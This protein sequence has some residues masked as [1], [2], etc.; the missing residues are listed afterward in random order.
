MKTITTI[1][2]LGLKDGTPI[3]KGSSL[4]FIRPGEMPTVGIFSYNGRELKMRYRNVLKNPSMRSLEKWSNDSVCK[5]VF[6]AVVEPDGYGPLNEP[7]W[8]LAMG[9]I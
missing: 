7:S 6:G 9:L 4:V 2:D 1:K 8:L 5:S 3:S